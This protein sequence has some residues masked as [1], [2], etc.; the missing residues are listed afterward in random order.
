[1][2]H[3]SI[4]DTQWQGGDVGWGVGGGW[5]TDRLPAWMRISLKGRKRKIIISSMATCVCISRRFR[6]SFCLHGNDYTHVCVH[7]LVIGESGCVWK[8]ERETHS[9]THIYASINHRRAAFMSLPVHVE[10]QPNCQT[11]TSTLVLEWKAPDCVQCH[12]FLCP[13]CMC[14]VK[15]TESMVMA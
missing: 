15:V 1:M 3:V 12:R 11:R 9:R 2:W 10:S 5:L 6:G 14:M 8:R 13:M 4:N 7:A